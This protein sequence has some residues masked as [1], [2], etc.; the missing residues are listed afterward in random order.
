MSGLG[1]GLMNKDHYKR[2]CN[3]SY[4]T[5]PISICFLP[6]PAIAFL[7]RGISQNE[8]HLRSTGNLREAFYGTTYENSV[9]VDR[10]VLK[11]RL[12]HTSSLGLS[13]TANRPWMHC[14]LSIMCIFIDCF[15]KV[16]I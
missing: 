5:Q 12:T 16:D 7:Q 4:I 6:G 11:V 8:M 9:I 2:I 15:M 14:R 10:L 1:I 13:T 3:S